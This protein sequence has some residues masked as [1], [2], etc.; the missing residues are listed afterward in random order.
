M[1]VSWELSQERRATTCRSK[2]SSSPYV[3]TQAPLLYLKFL[4]ALYLYTRRRV[5]PDFADSFGSP[6]WYLNEVGRSI[7][8]R[9]EQERSNCKLN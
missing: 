4:R 7:W 9:R 2:T 8:Q 1:Q 6:A 5:S 3:T